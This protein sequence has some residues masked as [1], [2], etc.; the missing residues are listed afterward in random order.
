MWDAFDVTDCPVKPSKPMLNKLELTLPLCS[1]VYGD[2][3]LYLS[4]WCLW[5]AKTI[6]IVHQGQAKFVWLLGKFEPSSPIACCA[7]RTDLILWLQ[8]RHN[9]QW[10]RVHLNTS[11]LLYLGM[12]SGLPTGLKI[13]D[14]Y[15]SKTVLL[16]DINK[17][18]LF[19]DP[20]HL[21]LFTTSFVAQTICSVYVLF[22]HW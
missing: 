4:K 8:W 13:T 16:I 1:L 17:N 19:I 11:N 5:N 20:G 9:T 6:D 3:G 2:K 12:T 7:P 22:E 10:I 21:P 18:R 14:F 15:W